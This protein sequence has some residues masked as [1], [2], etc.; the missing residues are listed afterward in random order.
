MLILVVG[1]TE[2]DDDDTTQADDDTTA[3]DDDS[4]D[5][6]SA[7]DDSADDDSADDDDT[8]DCVDSTELL[9]T[10]TAILAMTRTEDGTLWAQGDEYRWWSDRGKGWEPVDSLRGNGA[11]EITSE[12]LEIWIDDLEG[13]FYSEG[14]SWT[15]VPTGLPGGA[16]RDIAG[17]GDGRIALLTDEELPGDGGFVDIRLLVGDEGGF[18]LTDLGEI[19]DHG[20][21][22]G[23]DGTGRALA[24]AQGTAWLLEGDSWTEVALPIVDYWTDVVGFDGRWVL[25]SIYGT[26][27]R[28]SPGD[29]E[30]EQVDVYDPRL[31]GVTEVDLWL[32]GAV[33]NVEYETGVIWHSQGAGWSPVPGPTSAL[34]A[35]VAPSAGT[36]VVGGA[37]PSIGRGDAGGVEVEWTTRHLVGEG[38]AWSAPDGRVFL[39]TYY[40]Q[41]E[42]D[43]GGTWTNL[44]TVGDGGYGFEVYGCETEVFA[45]SDEGAFA[46]WDGATLEHDELA[47][48]EYTFFFGLGVTPDCVP[49]VAGSQSNYEEI[50]TPIVRYLT[51]EGWVE[52]PT[53]P[54]RYANNVLAMSLTDLLV[55][56][57]DGLYRGDGET[58]SPV[59]GTTDDVSDLAQT[60]DG[61]IWVSTQNA[62]LN[63]LVGDA[64]VPVSGTPSRI[65]HLLPHGDALFA[66]EWDDGLGTV[67]RWDGAW[68]AITTTDDV[69]ALMALEGE[70]YLLVLTW[71]TIT[72]VCLEDDAA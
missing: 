3:A 19:Q 6:D 15:E 54:D 72:R 37:G 51:D 64:L 25:V 47:T 2:H 50:T 14:I 60:S 53:L 9:P 10:D 48:D 43:D 22:I 12:G 40:G 38:D 32:V 5:D 44:G 56:T 42:V 21:V 41:L 45:M 49:V 55:S 1:C 34:H 29:W 30:I 46:T 11:S 23:G 18:V 26:V 63:E 13:V 31:A 59:S 65:D 62:G 27:L 61:R 39:A 28:G 68:E 4:V 16:V 69:S 71:E 24:A 66:M 33:S 58:W 35:A 57:S 70:S 67:H 7:D 36:V 20:R 17:L 52:L 8:D